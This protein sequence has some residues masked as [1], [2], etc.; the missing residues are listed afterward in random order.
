MN[1]T[2]HA[3][4]RAHDLIFNLDQRDWVSAGLQ[5]KE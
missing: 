5:K 1:S 2:I 3:L 4:Q